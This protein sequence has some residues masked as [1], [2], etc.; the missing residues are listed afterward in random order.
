VSALEPLARRYAEFWVR[1]TPAGTGE[2]RQLAT[3]EMRFTDP[4]NDVQGVER[5]VAL[6][7]HMFV[8]LDGPRFTIRD[9]ACSADAAFLLWDLEAGVRGRP[10]YGRVVIRGMS[11]IRFEAARVSLHHDHWDA[12]SQVYERLP[13]LGGLL[14]RVRRRFAF[15]S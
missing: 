13:L 4:F 1:L 10:R 7:D 8:T 2:L 14:K 3:P 5:V 12:A 11:E 6:L 15:E 9:L